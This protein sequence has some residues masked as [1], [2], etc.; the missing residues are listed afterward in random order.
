MNKNNSLVC[1]ILGEKFKME[2]M[3]PQRAKESQKTSEGIP[4]S[5]TVAIPE[6]QKKRED[7]GSMDSIV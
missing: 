2:R 4:V 3:V 6:T 7:R 5:L 1:G